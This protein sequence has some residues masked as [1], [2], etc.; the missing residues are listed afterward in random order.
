MKRKHCDDMTWE[1][2]DNLG[3]VP[4]LISKF[5]K[6]RKTQL[7][8]VHYTDDTGLGYSICNIYQ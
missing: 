2:V 5:E 1:P 6:E 8:S 3:S 4:H 7:E